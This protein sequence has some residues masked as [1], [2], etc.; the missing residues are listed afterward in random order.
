MREMFCLAE[1]FVA[2]RFHHTDDAVALCSS[3]NRGSSECYCS[4]IG[5]VSELVALTF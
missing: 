3:S 1:L 5:I 2:Q 4:D